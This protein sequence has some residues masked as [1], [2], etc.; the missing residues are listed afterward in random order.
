SSSALSFDLR[1]FKL[2]GWLSL[3]TPVDASGTGLKVKYPTVAMGVSTDHLTLVRLAKD[4]KDRK[5]E[6]SSWEVVELPP[7]LVDTEMF[8]VKIKSEERFRA[9]VAGALQREGV[10][11]PA[12]SL[13][14]PDHLARVSLLAFEELP[15]TRRELIEMIRWKMKKAVPFKVEEAV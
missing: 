15:R 2:P 4:K 12:I 13:V 5:W 9:L 10:R 3:G 6:M 1:R 14:L 11:T 7:D 8:H